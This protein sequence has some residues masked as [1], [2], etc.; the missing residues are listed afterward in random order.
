MQ[1]ARN[2]RANDHHLRTY[3]IRYFDALF[4]RLE[5]RSAIVTESYAVDQLVLYKLAGEH[6]DRGRTIGLIT[7]DVETVRQHA[8]AGFAVYAFAEGRKALESHGYRFEPIPLS[9]VGTPSTEPIDMSPLPL[10]RLTRLTTCQDIGNTGWQDITNLARD[11]R[12]LIRIDNY[13][14]FDSAVVLYAGQQSATAANPLLAASHGPEAPSM[15]VTMFQG[16]DSTK[17]AAAVQRDGLVKADP[18]EREATVQRIELRVNDHGDFSWSALDLG[19]HPDV[20]LARASVDLNNPRR[21]SFCGWSGRDLFESGL[22]ERV[23]FGPSGENSFGTGWHG[24]ER[25]NE[26]VDFRWTSAREAE[27]LIPL[28]K[29]RNHHR[30]SPRG[31]VHLPGVAADDTR[32]ESE[33]R[34]TDCTADAGWIGHVRVGSAGTA[35]ASGIQ[36]A[37]RECLEPRESCSSRALLRYTIAGCCGERLVAPSVAGCREDRALSARSR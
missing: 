20:V 33:W 29:T 15:A 8:A 25:S 2:Y 5:A 7:R 22:E 3:E 37:C 17:L 10:F 28:T 12:L 9:T 1:L 11:G 26:G 4:D 31:S 35:L 14:P 32:S 13:R 6:A 16:A 36:S 18:L 34:N 23:S 19:G 30:A 21:A 27:V 24:A